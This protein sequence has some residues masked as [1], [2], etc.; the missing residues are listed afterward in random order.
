[1]AESR[2]SKAQRNPPAKPATRR[3]RA[4]KGRA[5][6]RVKRE[7]PAMAD[8]GPLDEFAGGAATRRAPTRNGGIVRTVPAPRPLHI[9][10]VGW[11]WPPNHTGGLG[12]H[13][14]EISK[15]LTHL[16]HRITFLTPFSGPFTPV[17]GVTFRFPGEPTRD[18]PQQYPPAYW[19]GG[20]PD[21]PFVD[22]TDGYNA[23]ISLLNEL[24]P[25]DVI[26]V[27][28]WFGTVGGRALARRLRVPLIMTVHSTEY[29][30]SLG[31]PWD[32]ILAREQ[33]GIDAAA[34][35]IAVSRHLRQQ[36]IDRYHAD[37]GRVRVIYNAVRPTQRLERIDPAKRVVLYV[38]RLAA[39]KGVD[40]YLRAAARLV[41]TFP[42][43]LFV[44]AGEGPEYSRLIQLAAALE[45][46]DHVMFLGKVTEE[47]R[48]LLLAGSS[49][50]VLP[51]VVE[52]FGIAALEA[53]AAGVPTIVSK[54]SGVAEISSGSFRV[55]FW[56]ADEFASRIAEL[57]EYPTLRSAMGEQGRWEALREGWPERARETVGV[58]LEAMRPRGRA[59]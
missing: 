45:I 44:V 23:W 10:M 15:E 18:A 33:I 24:G 32:H 42:D 5:K 39:M 43:V 3:R 30:R 46:G 14:F 17:D 27:H 13:S 55:D 49:V 36:L 20:N 31:H 26:H 2:G 38:G 25:V 37:P 28:D 53:M 16:G 34:R 29:D 12:V 22:A 1:M 11:E 54:T 47:E 56:D 41:P 59:P 4:T 7:R 9:V 57:L 8:A 50:F 40:T 21:S 51:S 48:E 19:A 58:Y 52:P 35:V 6:P